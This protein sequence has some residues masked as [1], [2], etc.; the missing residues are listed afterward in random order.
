MMP[1]RV[2]SF[3]I[4][5]IAILVLG[6]EGGAGSTFLSIGTGGTGGIYYP[7]GGALASR[8]SSRL[9]D[10]R[11]TAEVTAASV[12]NIK[13][14]QQGQID[15]GM[16]IAL[17]LP[18]AR[19][20]GPD[21][22]QPFEDL[23]VIAPMWPN[24]LNVLVPQSSD[25]R[26]IEDLRGRTVSVGAPGSGTEMVTRVVLDA[27][28]MSYDDID[29]RF[30]SFTESSAGIR[31]GSVDA[32]FLEVAFPAAAVM[33]AATTASARIL[34]LAGPRIDALIASRAYFYGTVIPAGAYR[35]VTEDI[36][37]IGELNWIVARRDLDAEVVT[38]ILDILYEDRDALIEVNQ[39]VSQIDL[40]NLHRA[41]I[42]LHPAAQ[43]WLDAHP[44]VAATGS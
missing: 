37:T 18:E 26:S 27:F 1:S 17:A 3:A 16:S 23:T 40:S 30:L 33:E 9:A 22:A 24:P 28:D 41:P 4:L 11:F 21:F 12:E 32:A 25:I 15:I 14:L 5:A 13:R 2:R 43:A 34:P 36:P 39:A 44:D 19:S 6:C 10:R 38:A 31:D 7:F 20:G 42:P 35:G 29:E 8:L